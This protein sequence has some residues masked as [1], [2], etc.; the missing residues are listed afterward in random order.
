MGTWLGKPNEMYHIQRRQLD[1]THQW[2]FLPPST[3]NQM[4]LLDWK[5]R[6]DHDG[7][8]SRTRLCTLSSDVE[9]RGQMA[10][11][12]RPWSRR[13]PDGAFLVR[14]L[15]R[16]LNTRCGPSIRGVPSKRKYHRHPPTVTSNHR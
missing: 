2:I 4:S 14:V 11:R 5:N 13:A 10:M 16:P 1:Q 8:A 15:A 12:S 6:Q 9:S 7:H 3:S